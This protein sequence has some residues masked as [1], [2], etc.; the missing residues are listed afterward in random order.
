ML[1]QSYCAIICYVV[2]YSLNEKQNFKNLIE[3]LIIEHL[4]TIVIYFQ[5]LN[6]LACHLL[7]VSLSQ[8]WDSL[9]GVFAPEFSRGG[10]MRN[11][12]KANIASAVES[13]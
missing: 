12:S 4:A 6:A 1:S 8:N 5:E 13:C 2:R 9:Q 3:D 7:C 11:K 10:V